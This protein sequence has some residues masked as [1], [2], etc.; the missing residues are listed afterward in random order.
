[1][2]GMLDPTVGKVTVRAT[3]EW[4]KKEELHG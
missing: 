3:V 2:T 4:F 1:M